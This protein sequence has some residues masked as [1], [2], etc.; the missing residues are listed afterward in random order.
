[1]KKIKIKSYTKKGWL[2]HE[3]PDEFWKLIN[4][5]EIDRN[6]LK[7]SAVDGKQMTKNVWFLWQPDKHAYS[8][9]YTVTFTQNAD[10]LC[11]QTMSIT[12][13]SLA[14]HGMK[15]LTITRESDGTYRAL[16]KELCN[17]APDECYLEDA[18]NQI[19]GTDSGKISDVFI[20]HSKVV[21]MLKLINISTNIILKSYLNYLEKNQ[22]ND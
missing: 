20:N 6:K 14:I 8:L 5:D 9:D 2:E 16:A 3:F 19:G 11:M 15:E 17:F 22:K 13:V 21:D 10:Q 7:I 18:P 12:G 4:L 1:M